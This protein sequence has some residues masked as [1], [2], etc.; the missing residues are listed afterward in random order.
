MKESE[1][2]AGKCNTHAESRDI[3]RRAANII[4]F[5]LRAKYQSKVC[6]LLYNFL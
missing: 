6:L 4:F 3:S 2:K 5:P 1:Y